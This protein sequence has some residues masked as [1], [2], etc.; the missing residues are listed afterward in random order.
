MK[1]A[2][3]I[4]RLTLEMLETWNARRHAEGNALRAEIRAHMRA[5]MGPKRLSAKL[6][7]ALL[8]KDPGPSL[9]RIQEHMKFINAEPS[10]PRFPLKHAATHG[11]ANCCPTS[12][13]LP[14]GGGNR[15][16]IEPSN[17]L[18]PDGTR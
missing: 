8:S 1:S 16:R 11:N 15:N 12:Q 10:A 7:Q 18:P 5:H 17:T 4:G 9:R 2:H 3:E 6:I 14:F 13:L